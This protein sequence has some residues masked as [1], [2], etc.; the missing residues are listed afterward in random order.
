MSEAALETLRATREYFR[1][2]LEHAA[3]SPDPAS[4]APGTMK[5][6][7]RRLKQAESALKEAS[8]ALTASGEWQQNVAEY[9]KTL[10]ELRA[11]LGNL[12]ITLRIR[13][14]QMAQKRTQLDA[15]HCWADL[16]KHIG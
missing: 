4:H 10:R 8:P 9:V 14:A 3:K 1:D 15:I 12:E 16:A 6:M 7:A 11:R 2:W 5:I 13:T